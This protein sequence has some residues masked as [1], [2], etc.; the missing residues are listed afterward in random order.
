[1]QYDQ[2]YKFVSQLTPFLKPKKWQSQLQSQ[3]ELKYKFRVKWMIYL[4]DPVSHQIS[5]FDWFRGQFQTEIDEEK[6][7]KYH[8]IANISFDQCVNKLDWPKYD[9]MFDPITGEQ[10]K[11]ASYINPCFLSINYFTRWL[12]GISNV[13][14]YNILNST[15]SVKKAID[16]LN[17]IYDFVGLVEY[18]DES[19][20]YLTQKFSKIF[21][22][23]IIQR[24]LYVSNTKEFEAGSSNNK[25]QYN[26][27]IPLK[28]SVR[29]LRQFGYLDE[30]LYKYV[31]ARFETCI[32]PNI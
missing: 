25:F 32:L 5:R 20:N 29:K 26:K 23:K 30:I 9:K 16:N 8:A 11:N 15:N 2:E 7:V 6:L 28:S 31:K 19:W 27:T 17:T 14:Q 22:P 12:C 18:Y 10:N 4:R 1:M 13:C 24:K 21:N 3:L